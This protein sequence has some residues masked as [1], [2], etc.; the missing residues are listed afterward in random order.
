M[1]KL[2]MGVAFALVCCMAIS[3]T[4]TVNAVEG[5]GENYASV[6]DNTQK[7]SLADGVEK[8][9]PN[10]A[11]TKAD[12]E[13]ITVTY[14]AAKLKVVAESLEI[15]R[16]ANYAWIGIR[17]TAPTS[18]TYYQVKGDEKATKLEDNGKTFDE[19][20]GI[21]EAKLKASIENESNAIVYDYEITWYKNDP[22]TKPE[23]ND[24]TI[25][26]QKIKVIIKS[27]GVELHNDLDTTDETLWD[28]DIYQAEVKKVEDAKKAAE[29]SKA[30]KAE[31]KDT[32]PKT[33]VVDY[34]VY[35]AMVT[36]IVAL[37]GIYTVKKLVK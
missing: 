35:V 23:E 29:Q 36:A 19:Y 22:S 25:S 27:S 3:F 15:G 16:P 1:K 20:F 31:E 14:N 10:I 33:G 11:V 18:A 26:T 4:N 17:M 12:G 30:K 24:N 21:S 7:D 34:S 13:E 8:L 5:V 6:E 28:N 9:E 32:T 37:G 2:F